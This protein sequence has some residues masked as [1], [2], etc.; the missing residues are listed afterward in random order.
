MLDAMSRRAD[1]PRQ[2]WS[3]D[4]ATLA[5]S[6]HAWELGEDFSGD[7]LLLVEPDLVLAADATI[8]YREDLRRKLAVSGIVPG[9]PTASHLI[10]AAYRAW[11]EDCPSR[12]EGDFAFVLWDRRK[13]RGFCSR[14][15]LAKRPL[16]F[17]EAPKTLFVASTIGG[18]LAHPDVPDALHPE[19]I[20]ATAAGFMAAGPE[21]C[22]AAVERLPGGT[23]LRWSEGTASRPKRHWEPSIEP[24]RQLSFD[25]AADH[26]RH[27]LTAAVQ[28][29]LA[30]AGSS[31]IWM[32]GGWD[33]PAVFG[34]GQAL[35]A[36]GNRGSRLS[37]VSISYPPGDPGREDDLIEA[38]AGSWGARVHWLDID[39]IPFFDP[40]E[41]ELIERDEP[42]RHLYEHWNRALARGSRS[43]GSRVALDGN[44]G[45]QAFQVSPIYL[46]D[47]FRSGRWRELRRDWRALGGSGFRLFFRTAIQPI[48][49]DYLM[50]AAARLRGGRRLARYGER[51][52]PSWFSED[53][54]RSTRLAERELDH[55]PG[56][57]KPSCARAETAWY[58]T[59]FAQQRVISHL[60]GFALE[61]GVELRSPLADRRIVEFALSRPRE[62]RAF[63]R[64]T[65]R[66]LRRAVRG[67]LPDQ[68]LAPRAHRTGTTDGFSH[69]QVFQHLSH[70]TEELLSEP[71]LLGEMGIVKADGFR[72]AVSA[73]RDRSQGDLRVALLYTYHTERWLRARRRR[74]TSATVQVPSQDHIRY[75]VA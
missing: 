8:H 2:V 5:V 60:A 34:A 55:L 46:A 47:L 21:T 57:G 25:D 20:A 10:A 6:R 71:L 64:E 36:Q 44:G 31:S 54:L 35:L 70:L 67:W 7:V 65:K 50:H 56:P 38:I 12:L 15:F 33:S 53:F 39:R 66:L 62:E 58:W 63:G 18:V 52:T 29:R 68:V 48:L 45:D 11:A 69:R 13:R 14:D 9:G 30:R 4:G 22:F 32:S 3:G 40:P 72:R 41:T 42:F 28:E 61:E 23:D 24:S 73:Y 59:S 19:S 26:L 1:G 49:P 75:L 43:T 51:W 16:H 17:A 27:L 74:F 37:P